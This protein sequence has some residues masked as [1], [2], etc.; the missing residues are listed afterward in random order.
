MI[1]RR[2]RLNLL[3][4][5]TL[6]VALSL[7]VL[8]IADLVTN[9][10]VHPLLY[11]VGIRTPEVPTEPRFLSIQVLSSKDQ[12]TVTVQDKQVYA[13]NGKQ[14]GIHVVVLNQITGVVM[15]TRVFDTYLA[16]TDEMMV[17]FLNSISEQRILCFA[18]LD[19]G[20]FS[21]K[22]NGR[23]GLKALGSR[24]SASLSWR[25]MW[26]FVAVKGGEALAEDVGKSVSLETWGLAVHLKVSVAVKSP[27]DPALMCE[28]PDTPTNHKRRMFCA[29]Y[30]G[31]GG[32]CNCATPLKFDM[33]APRLPGSSKDFNI[34][35]AVMASNRPH[36]LFRMLR[37]LLSAHGS[38]NSLVTVF[39]DGFF[40]EPAEVANLFGINSV[41]HDPMSEKNGRISQHY[42][43]SLSKMFD[44]H[45]NAPY[46]LIIEEDLDVSLD[47]FSYFSQTVHLLDKDSSLYCIS[48]WNDQGYTHSCNDPALL[49]RVET[50]PGLGWIL[51]RDLFKKELEPIWPGPDKLW[52]WDMW[53]RTDEVRKGRECIIPDVSR[54]YHFGSSGLNMN[55][56]FQEVYFSKH[57]LNTVP[58]VMLNDV[59]SLQSE[60]YELV[61][62]KLLRDAVLLDHSKVPCDDHFIP[63]TKNKIY[64]M[65][66]EMQSERDFDH[67]MKVATCFK[68]WDLDARGFH[69]GLWRLW[70][71]G[72]Q[73]L[74]VGHPYSPY[75]SKYKPSDVKPLHL[76]TPKST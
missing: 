25:D 74:V 19:E 72:N 45:P 38:N 5:A 3:L 50:M 6:V 65:Y 46:I 36:Y 76:A 33:Q 13:N 49:Y 43:R 22:D 31:Y 16:G 9:H 48:A 32:L 69:K 42:R 53:M 51:K 20:T 75:S 27:N 34:P 8:F 39:I 55:P 61:I 2:R 17:V 15:A 73:V 28:W 58:D 68:I 41:Q 35:V 37:S 23:N 7:N 62:H 71:K 57:V 67:W 21:L 66:I 1:C 63:N 47:L 10:Q 14:R 24:L 60:P 59:E 26:A 11:G 4:A 64:V 29:N 18:I 40:R 12:V 30:E 52:D 70:L 56:Y 44:M 54:T